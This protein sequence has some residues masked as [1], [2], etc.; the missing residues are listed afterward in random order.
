MAKSTG[1]FSEG[2]GFDS[3]HTHGSSR[4]S[5]TP[6]LADLVASF[7][8]HRYC[9]YALYPHTCR[10]NTQVH[11]IKIREFFNLKKG[12]TIAK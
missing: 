6:D 8:S 7:S 10:Q 5:V 4:L 2:P 9:I 1:Y 3:Q 12:E 11:K